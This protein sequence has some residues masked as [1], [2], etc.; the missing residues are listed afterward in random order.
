[1]NNREEL[2]KNTESFKKSQYGFNLN[3]KF[4]TTN[5]N[6]C[7]CENMTIKIVINYKLGAFDQRSFIIY[8]YSLF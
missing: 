6:I 7:F 5:L 4:Q 8:I 2:R 3:S 1:M